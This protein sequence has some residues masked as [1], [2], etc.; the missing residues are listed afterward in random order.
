MQSNGIWTHKMVSKVWRNILNVYPE[1][2][3]THD[4]V[5]HVWHD[6]TRKKWEHNDIPLESAQKLIEQVS[7]DGGL[8]PRSRAMCLID[9]GTCEYYNTIPSC[10]TLTK[11]ILTAIRI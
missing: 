8:G 9:L 4:A 2:T 5:Y 3:F 7:V 10:K 1:P 6:L 11:L